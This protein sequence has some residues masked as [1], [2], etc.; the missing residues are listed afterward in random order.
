MTEPPEPPRPPD[1][2]RATRWLLDQRE[3]K[4]WESFSWTAVRPLIAS[5]NDLVNKG[6]PTLVHDLRQAWVT[7]QAHSRPLC[8]SENLVV[9]SPKRATAGPHDP[10]DSRFIV[11][12]DPGEQDASQY[13][14]VPA[15]LEHVDD[16][17]FMVICSDLTYPSGDINDYADGFYIPYGEVPAPPADLPGLRKIGPLRGLPAYA[18]PGNHDWYD[19]LTGFMWHLCGAESLD[20]TVYGPPSGS[21][22]EWPS[23]LLWRRP[24]GRMSRLH[25]EAKRANRA[26]QGQ[27]WEPRQP[28]PYY[29]IDTGH[30]ML[31]CIDTGIDGTIDREQGEWLLRVSGEP[32]PKILLT[33]KPLLVNRKDDPCKIADGPVHLD[34]DRNDP[35]AFNSVYQVVTHPPHNYV[36]T[37]GGDIHN[38]QHYVRDGV[39]HI[40]SG[41]GGA[42][43]KATHTIPDVGKDAP[44]AQDDELKKLIPSP[45]DSLQYF[46][47]QLLPRL[48]HLVREIFAMLAGI[49][50]GSVLV[51]T[52]G[53]QRPHVLVA[54]SAALGICWLARALVLTPGFTQTPRYRLIAMVVAC[55]AGVVLA[56][57]G[58]WLA[59]GRYATDAWGWLALSGGSCAISWLMRETGWWRSRTPEVREDPRWLLPLAAL[60]AA[61]PVAVA[62]VSRDWI[63]TAAALMISVAALGGWF[64]RGRS[65]EA[66][67]WKSWNRW[68]PIIAY[69]V[70]TLAALLILYA[71]VIP[72]GRRDVLWASTIGATGCLALLGIGAVIVLCVVM[73]P[74]AAVAGLGHPHPLRAGW[75]RVGPLAPSALLLIIGFALW[76]S[77]HAFGLSDPDA[78]GRRGAFTTVLMIVCLVVIP[79]GLDAVR[80]VFGR[81]KYKGVLILIG[82][83]TIA[84][85]TGLGVF[86][87][88]A[89][90]AAAAG[91]VVVSA[92]LF[93]V[94]ISH[95]TFLGAFWLVWDRDE[96][97]EPHLFTEAEAHQVIDWRHGGNR[98][99]SEA[100]ARRAMI[101]FPGLFHPHGPLQDA[102][103]EIFDSDKPPFYKNF[104]V[105][106]S[107]ADRLKITTRLVTGIE[108]SLDA[109]SIEIPIDQGRRPS[110]PDDALRG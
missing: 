44:D 58:W 10:D 106:D 90:K 19:G 97:G 56:M 59:P 2:M 102:V 32:K 96:R 108:R 107:R 20:P 61:L 34:G 84:A 11:L 86:D 57:A 49:G 43:M 104:L 41:G 52:A 109:W 36:A 31:V 28:G 87:T 35:H 93:S 46:A 80:R 68:A 39:Q 14:V 24:S 29:A 69:V 92:T 85:L 6:A 70:Q 38:F 33:G 40:V 60:L 15:L 23:R 63:L 72:P 5:L 54:C 7:M 101:V 89:P 4:K 55:L 42:Y 76:G 105:L 73:I 3:Q 75:G 21:L 91:L 100:V 98:P 71:L 79:L 99:D 26:P 1:Q 30:V 62:V 8:W 12:G 94:V 13:V 83:L 37:I 18:L 67:D 110:S 74:V 77:W 66:P 25:L 22:L 51:S 65:H 95:L 88:S 50:L 82:L 47:R 17:D 45:T 103:S 48:W 81:N 9:R 64:L 16:V 78:H 53:G 27:A